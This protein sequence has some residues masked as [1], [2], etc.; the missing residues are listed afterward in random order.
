MKFLFSL[1]ASWGKVADGGGARRV[2]LAFWGVVAIVLS[3]LS[4]YAAYLLCTNIG[5][6][7]STNIIVGIFAII[8]IPVCAVFAIMFILQGVVA[9]IAMIIFTSLSIKNGEDKAANILALII[10]AVSVV[11]A[12]AA[13]IVLVVLL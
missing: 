10:A 11:G 13:V 12:V 2:W 4:V 3:G 1:F 6:I 9:Q 8:G 7:L 5:D